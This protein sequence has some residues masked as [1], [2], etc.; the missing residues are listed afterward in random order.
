MLTLA[1]RSADALVQFANAQGQ[2]GSVLITVVAVLL[3]ALIVRDY[4]RA[5]VRPAILPAPAPLVRLNGRLYAQRASMRRQAWAVDAPGRRPM[6]YTVTEW[7]GTGYTSPSI[8]RWHAR[9]SAWRLRR[10]WATVR[11]PY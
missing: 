1:A 10:S 11:Y 8:L 9:R 2:I 5:A 6:R 3:M 7:V 4:L